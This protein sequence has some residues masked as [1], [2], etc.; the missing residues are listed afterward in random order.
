MITSTNPYTQET[1]K[2][3]QQM[4]WDQVESKINQAHESFQSR[5]KTSFA[6]RKQLM[7]NLAKLMQEQFEDLAKLDTQEMGMLY[8]D[9]KGDVTKSA[10]NVTYF[11][12]H[13]ETLLA[14]KPFDQDG[15]K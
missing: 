12:E 2:T 8:K 6:E 13:A 15:L 14:P 4:T 1:T 11:A 3:Y 10:S 5:K 9:A 7:N